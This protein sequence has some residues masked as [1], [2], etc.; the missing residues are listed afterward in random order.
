MPRNSMLRALSIA[1][2]SLARPCSI[3][4]FDIRAVFHDDFVEDRGAFLKLIEI[5]L[6]EM[7]DVTLL[8]SR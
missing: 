2:L 3:C 8:R 1:R 5:D 7:I 6:E 4:L